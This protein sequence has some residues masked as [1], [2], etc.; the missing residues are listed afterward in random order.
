MLIFTTILHQNIIDKHDDKPVQ[1]M[2]NYSVP[3]IHTGNWC[4][5]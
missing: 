1:V 3:Q 4:I 2:A 5:S